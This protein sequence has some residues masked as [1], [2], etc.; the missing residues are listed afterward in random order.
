[1]PLNF[2]CRVL[3]KGL[4]NR[5]VS[6]SCDNII[7]AGCVAQLLTCLTADP[8]VASSIPA[9]TYTFMEIDHKIITMAILLHSAGSRRVVVSYKYVHAVL[10]N[11]LVKFAQEKKCG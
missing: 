11:R 7:K 4:L 3:Y 10:V 9:W 6:F 5:S 2:E 8:G 1:M